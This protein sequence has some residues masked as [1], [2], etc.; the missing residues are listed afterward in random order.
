V[1]VCVVCTLLLLL[2]SILRV[3]MDVEIHKYEAGLTE[4]TTKVDPAK[5]KSMTL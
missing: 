4:D 2:V 3:V 5:H 1:F